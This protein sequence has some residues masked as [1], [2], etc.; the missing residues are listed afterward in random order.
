MK[1]IRYVIGITL[2]AALS[3]CG[4]MKMAAISKEID[5]INQEADLSWASDPLLQGL[6]DKV[7]KGEIAKMP[8]SFALNNAKPSENDKAAIARYIEHSVNTQNKYIELIKDYPGHQSILV[9]RKAAYMSLAS[10][11]YSGALTYGEYNLKVQELWAK[12]QEAF[13]AQDAQDQAQ[14]QANYANFLRMQQ[15]IQ[16][17]QPKTVTCNTF[18]N[19]TTCR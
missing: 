19:T 14:A 10:S 2:L 15:N 5:K 4:A 8:V 17:A 1:I 7:F 16:A 3:G 13:N 6:S 9:S 12:A 11:L 18:G